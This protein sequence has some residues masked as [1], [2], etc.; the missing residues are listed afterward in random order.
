M[1]VPRRRPVSARRRGATTPRTVHGRPRRHGPP[2][3]PPRRDTRVRLRRK[4]L[5]RNDLLR[6][7]TCASPRSRR[8]RGS[9]RASCMAYPRIFG[10]SLRPIRQPS[11]PGTTSRRSLATSGSAG[12]SPSRDL[13]RGSSTSRE[14]A[15]S[16]RRE[17]ADPAVG[18]VAL[19]VERA[20]GN[21]SRVVL[22]ARTAVHGGPR[23]LSTAA[24][25]GPRATEGPGSVSS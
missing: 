14:C 25:F 12:S 21:R 11:Q 3:R 10:G 7:T 24:R 23:R 13:R 22:E 4:V 18:Q 19:I 16:S 20:L 1:P 17:C 9:P 5:P 2:S 15:P 6:G 8:R